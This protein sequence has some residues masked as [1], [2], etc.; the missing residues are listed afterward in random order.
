MNAVSLRRQL[1]LI[2]L[3]ATALVFL[4]LAGTVF[5]LM[6]YWKLSTQ[7]ETFPVAFETSRM[8]V[9]FGAL[10]LLSPIAYGSASFAFQ[11]KRLMIPALIL[12]LV[13]YAVA[14][15]MINKGVLTLINTGQATTDFWKGSRKL[16][17]NFGHIVT[18][19]YAGLVYGSLIL[20]KRKKQSEPVAIELQSEVI[21]VK[22]DGV[23]CPLPLSSI[24]HIQANDHY[25]RLHQEGRFHLIRKSMKAIRK[26]LN[27]DFVQIHRSTII[28]RHFLK[29]LL[30]ESGSLYVE[31][32]DDTRLRV[33]ASFEQDV[34]K[35]SSSPD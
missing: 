28:N 17:L 9:N 5:L 30:K 7:G 26:E 18:L 1:P 12:G 13:F 11:K 32:L 29:R 35:L 8:L 34:Y 23:D 10:A 4:L 19:T 21:I 14:Y 3:S 27:A 6:R 2:K 33:S 31:M 22:V 16:F 15:L 24:S 25:L 20:I